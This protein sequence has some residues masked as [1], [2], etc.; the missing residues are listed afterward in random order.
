MKQIF[1]TTTINNNFIYKIFLSFSLSLIYAASSQVYLIF[2]FKLI[3]IT[4]Q[5]FVLFISPIIFGRVAF[6]ATLAWILQG[7]LGMP[8]FFGGTS[9]LIHI[10]G[11]TGGYLLGFLLSS[12][13][14]SHKGRFSLSKK[15]L[16]ATIVLHFCGIIYSLNF[17]NFNLNTILC[18]LADLAK[19]SLILPIVYK[20]KKSDF[21]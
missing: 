17:I 14:L 15:L 12:Y 9:G 7:I 8:V 19:I 20:I 5:T 6:Y 18:F 2:P 1:H 16:I 3:P 13:Y 10:L 21:N 4:L 11:P